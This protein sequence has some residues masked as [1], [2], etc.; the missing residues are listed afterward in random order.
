M[1]TCPIC[2]RTFANRNQ[3]HTCRPVGDLE[4][5]FQ[6]SEPAVRATFDRLLDI[7][8]ALGPVTVL[9]EKTRIALHV[10]MSFAAL[11][12]RRRWLDGH[13]VLARRLDSPRFR[14]I[15][16]YSPQ[17]VLHAFRL[18]SPAEADDEVAAWF[19][20]AYAVGEQRHLDRRAPRGGG[21][22]GSRLGA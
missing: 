19:A 16:T 13:V 17:N 1:W 2:D 14:R 4:G 3:S 6:R 8:A 5:H 7:V 15:E 9:P 10:R 20:E 12:P 21:R 11:I 22:K 18:A